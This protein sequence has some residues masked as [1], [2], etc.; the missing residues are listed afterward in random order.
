MQPA[1]VLLGFFLDQ[2]FVL[3]QSVFIRVKYEFYLE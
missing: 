1:F 3:V 2:K